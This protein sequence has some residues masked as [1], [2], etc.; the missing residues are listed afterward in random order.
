MKQRHGAIRRARVF[1]RASTV[2]E[3]A[4]WKL[5][6]NRNFVG[7]KFRR[8]YPIGRY[9]V[10]FAC[11]EKRIVIEADGKH[12]G[13]SWVHDRARDAWIASR[14]FSVLRFSNEQILC[15]PTT[16]VEVIVQALASDSPSPTE[17]SEV[18]EGVGG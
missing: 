5:L 18:G 2:A 1:R 7:L 16:V 6:R 8:Q 10:D 12:H 14:G 4:L 11:V 9:I 17:R 15:A 3:C 13:H